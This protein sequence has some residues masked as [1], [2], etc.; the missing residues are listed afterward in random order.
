MRVKALSLCALI[1]ASA[2]VMQA[3]PAISDNVDV[4]FD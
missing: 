1:V 4:K 3:W 2:A